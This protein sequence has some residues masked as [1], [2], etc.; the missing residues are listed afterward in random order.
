VAAAP[1]EE[2]GSSL[3]PPPRDTSGDDIFEG[4]EDEGKRI[5]GFSW[6]LAAEVASAEDW[7]RGCYTPSEVL[8]ADKEALLLEVQ[9]LAAG[10][11]PPVEKLSVS[12]ARPL[13]PPLEASARAEWLEG[14]QVGDVLDFWYMDKWW[15]VEL[16]QRCA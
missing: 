4:D 7:S 9:W 13:P 16:M 5:D 2:G 10:A 11:E 6:G 3:P 12:R 8:G 15:K 1:S 14:L